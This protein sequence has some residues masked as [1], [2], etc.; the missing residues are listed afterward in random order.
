MKHVCFL[1]KILFGTYLRHIAATLTLFKIY[2]AAC[3]ENWGKISFALEKRRRGP[4]D[5]RWL[6]RI[7]ALQMILRHADQKTRLVVAG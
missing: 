3:P 2:W 7:E 4:F 5:H 6:T 1:V